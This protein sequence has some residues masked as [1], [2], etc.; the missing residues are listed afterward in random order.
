MN[1][2]STT[3]ALSVEYGMIDDML[4]P[5][6]IKGKDY[7]KEEETRVI[8]QS[9]RPEIAEF[10]KANRDLYRMHCIWIQTLWSKL[11]SKRKCGNEEIKTF[12]TEIAIYRLDC[13]EQYIHVQNIWDR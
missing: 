6:R 4:Y 11:C 10:V 9:Q 12:S 7:S 3:L 13:F 5:T 2:R 8:I 1:V